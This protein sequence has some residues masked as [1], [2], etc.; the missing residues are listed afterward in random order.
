MEN[1]EIILYTAQDGSTTIELRAD[2]GTVWLTQAEIATLFQTT[3]QNISLHIKNILLEKELPDPVVKDNL[4]TASDGKC[5]RTKIYNLSMILAIGYRVESLRGTQFRRWATIHLQ[6]YL[7]KGFVMA[8]AR[9]KDSG[10]WDYFDEL[11]ERIREIRASEKR[12]YQKVRD[13]YST[14]ADY[15]PRSD[16]AQF[17]FKKVQNKMLWATTHHTAAEL[18][19]Q[20]TNSELPNM[21]LKSWK[22]SRVRQQDVAIAKNYLDQFEIDEL[23]RIVIMYLDYAED[24]AKR[25]NILVMAEWEQK[26]DAFLAFNERDILAHAG[27]VSAKVAEKLA[28]ECY[29]KFDKKRRLEEKKVA[30]AEDIAFLE[31]FHAKT[32]LREVTP[33]EK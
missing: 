33:V 25:R 32:E 28:I 4:T 15:D 23:N 30:D 20:R 11:L 24:Q 2:K 26:L 16:Q 31:E 12:F 3:K 18:I 14:A 6:E 9:L 22:G 29:N 13:I 27:R 7:V 21:G 5:Y 17:F 8:D 19:V 1:G 10:D